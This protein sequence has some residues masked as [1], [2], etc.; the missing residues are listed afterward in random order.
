[1]IKSV[2]LSV[3]KFCA[4]VQCTGMILLKKILKLLNG[5]GHVPRNGCRLLQ[6]LLVWNWKE[7][8]ACVLRPSPWQELWR[9]TWQASDPV[10][11]F[12][13]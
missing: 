12:P 11:G 5:S 1:M 7:P 9:S 10:A 8:Y 3:G 6:H 13:A 2:F 4:A